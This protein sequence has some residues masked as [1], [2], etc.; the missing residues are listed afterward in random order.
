MLLGLFSLDLAWTTSAVVAATSPLGI[1]EFFASPHSIHI[2]ID[3]AGLAISGGLF[4]VPTFSAV[5][6]WASADQ[7]ARVVAAV[8]VLN[9][10]FMVVGAI[11]L[12]VL[13]KVGLSRRSCSR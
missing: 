8:N 2:A 13:Q 6:A 12:A 11:V 1:R 10:V 3:L 4:I 7:R 9:A 5:Q